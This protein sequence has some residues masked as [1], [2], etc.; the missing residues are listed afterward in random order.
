MRAKDLDLIAALVAE[1]ADVGRTPSAEQ[2]ERLTY[3]TDCLQKQAVQAGRLDEHPCA[4]ILRRKTTIAPEVDHYLRNRRVMV[5]GSAGEIG[6]HL[7]RELAH[8]GLAE[9][10]GVDCLSTPAEA[11]C[12]RTHE[13]DISDR[14]ALDAVWRREKPEVVFH[15]AAIRDPGGAERSIDRSV[16]SNLVGTHQVCTL[17]ARYGA[18]RVI[19]ASSG[20][21]RLLYEE[22]VYPASKQL[23]EFSVR[24][25]ALDHPEVSW[26]CVRFH[27]V[28]DNSIVERRFREQLLADEPL[29]VHLPADKT[30]HGQ[31]AAE[32]VAMLLNAGALGADAE[33][34]GSSRQTDYFSILTLALYLRKILGGSAPILF[35]NPQRREGYHLAE[36]PGARRPKSADPESRTHSFN[37]LE[38]DLETLEPRLE[39]QLVYTRFPDFDAAATRQA[40][41]RL[42]T[43]EL[44]GT[45][46]RDALFGELK[47][48]SREVY[49][50]APWSR[51]REALVFA[52]A[53]GLLAQP[54]SVAQH[55]ATLELLYDSLEA[56]GRSPGRDP[57]LRAAYQSLSQAAED[58]V[59]CPAQ[60]ALVVFDAEQ[61]A[62]S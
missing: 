16:R 24:L 59:A 40:I 23:A 14:A 10:V 26:S 25:S 19:Y 47:E 39:L 4:G 2:R 5:T 62:T 6:G 43:T 44:R 8:R 36:F 28:V 1:G 13:V 58:W 21:C 53:Q 46:L 38:T 57:E 50:R 34:F 37:T 51:R 11:N 9:L 20:K 60:R 61:P 18:E 15:L 22:R 17:A 54:D 27:H 29:T 7:C 56:V 33:I 52:V 55:R 42:C 12:T 32:A 30:Q 35:T 49:R 3:L 41:D 31:S 45:A 48:V